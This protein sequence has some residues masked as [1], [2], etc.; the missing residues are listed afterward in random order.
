MVCTMKGLTPRRRY[1]DRL[2]SR[3]G[4]WRC[5]KE[6]DFDVSMPVGRSDD[7]RRHFQSGATAGGVVSCSFFV[8]PSCW[9]PGFPDDTQ[10]IAVSALAVGN[11][12]LL[13]DHSHWR[14]WLGRRDLAAQRSV[15]FESDYS[16]LLL[17][18]PLLLPPF[19]GLY[20]PRKGVLRVGR[21]VCLFRRVLVRLLGFPV[22][23]LGFARRPP[24]LPTSS[25]LYKRC[26]LSVYS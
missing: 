8:G 17:R 19:P 10:W 13:L 23:R 15:R 2:W 1:D 24:S 9:S 20:D 6:P 26:S 16:R 14:F 3:L 4:W 18:F 22:F 11:S 12:I 21:L 25:T 7:L 5:C